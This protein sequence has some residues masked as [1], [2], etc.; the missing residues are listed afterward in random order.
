[1]NSIAWPT[2]IHYKP[3]ECSAELE[4]ELA[5]QI[6]AT[7]GE[8]CAHR[9]RPSLIVSGGRTPAPLFKKLSHK[10]IP[11]QKIAITLADERWVDPSDSASNEKLVRS[12]LLQNKAA[13]AQFIGLKTDHST[14]AAGLQD[15]ETR[16]ADI[17]QPFDIVLLGMGDDGHTAS[18]FPDAPELNAALQSENMCQPMH[19]ASAEQARI[20]LTSSA[21]LNSR[22]IIVYIAGPQKLEVMSAAL[23]GNDVLHM[24]VRFLFQQQRVPVTFYW[25]PG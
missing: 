1:M 17:P 10:D 9:I 22:E 11:W 6:A 20:S 21:L 25:S 14:P 18:L 13:G 12:T 7:L 23:S 4:D 5:D 16:L 15:I 3:F 2:H 24:P 8:A 19:P